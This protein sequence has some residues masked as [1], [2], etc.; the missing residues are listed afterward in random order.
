M[1]TRVGII[2]GSESDKEI[3]R[4]AAD[5]LDQ[6]GVEWEARVISAHRSPELAKEYASTAKDRGIEV[7]I[8]GAGLS[9]HLPG[10]MAA[11]TTLPV[12]GV[13]IK[14][15]ALAGF[16][17]LLSISQMPP[18]VPVAAVGI[19]AARNAAILAC[20]I[21]ALKDADIAA[22]LAEMRKAQTERLERLKAVDV[23]KGHSP[24]R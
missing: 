20:E 14:A 15:G 21:L 8:A 5:V 17:A 9:A 22:R 3:M 11:W 19:D 16:D 18:G 7:I 10:V 12:I 13:P 23:L 6:V 4:E 1:T 24:E 2:F